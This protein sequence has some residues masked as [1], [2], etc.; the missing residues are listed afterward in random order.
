MEPKRAPIFANAWH[1]SSASGCEAE[2]FSR[3]CRGTVS[4]AWVLRSCVSVVLA[5]ASRSFSGACAS[6]KMKAPVRKESWQERQW[7]QNNRHKLQLPAPAT[8][9]M[10]QIVHPGSLASTASACQT[11]HTDKKKPT[12]L[13]AACLQ[14]ALK[15]A[16][17]PIGLTVHQDGA[18]LGSTRVRQA[19]RVSGTVAEL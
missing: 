17:G 18:K 1:I 13:L 12:V 19:L 11:N 14:M 6:R 9:I 4:T 10:L 7:R 16:A 15:D 5:S 3:K 2:A 8:T